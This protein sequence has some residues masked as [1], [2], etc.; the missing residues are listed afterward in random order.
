MYK[1]KIIT[2]GKTKEKW[3]SEGLE[4]YHK[5]LQAHMQIEW[6]LAKNLSGLISYAEKEKTY[7]SLDPKGLLLS[8]EEFS[9]EI[10]KQFEK[11]GSRISF[12]IGDAEGIPPSILSSS[13]LVLSFSPLTFTHQLCRL[14][15]LE[16]LYRA[17]EIAR[18][19]PYH[20]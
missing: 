7:I 11:G 9:K 13:R 10:Y 4:E 19:S 8:S 14:I 15:L 20:K 12:I 18:G 3:L 17:S 16:Q 5:R 2:V 1:V 6:L